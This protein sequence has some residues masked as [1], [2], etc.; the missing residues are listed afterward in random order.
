MGV[1]TQA[2]KCRANIEDALKVIVEN[3]TEFIDKETWGYDE[4]NSDFIRK[5]ENLLIDVIKARQEW[6][7]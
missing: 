1:E 2:D 5:T 3:A 4:Y 6:N 7:R